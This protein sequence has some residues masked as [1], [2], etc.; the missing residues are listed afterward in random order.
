MR[1]L[2]PALLAG[3]ALGGCAQVPAQGTPLA[4]EREIALP[5]VKGRI[6]HLAL[7]VA[8]HRLF[9]A[10][11]ANGSVDVIDLGGEFRRIAGLARPQGVAYLAAR[12]E[13]VV[14]CGGDG[15]VRFYDADTLALAGS[16]RLGEDADNIRV[17][18]ASGMIAVGYGGGAIALIDPARRAVVRQI[19]LPA[20]PEGFQID[21]GAGRLYV[22]LPDAG[23]VAAVDLAK[24]AVA[25]RWRAPH[26]LN[27]PMALG[28]DG[29]TVAI[30]SR[31][32]AHMSLL[33]AVSGALRLDP[34]TCGD[35]DDVFRDAARRR[36][37]V[38][39]GS[40]KVEVFSETAASLGF[41]KTGSGARTSLFSPSLTG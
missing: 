2:L 13:L 8:H 14:A 20:H 15:T 3:F 19:A 36:W 32:P 25:A 18:P 27:F 38:S 34:P 1:K 4:I 22:N 12:H 39:C 33:D 5:D 28:G 24:G 29:R 31:L 10:E 21:A 11:I 26:R 40:G 23:A 17:D 9:V 35:A 37:Y 7:D 41:V 6:D 30:V 16:I